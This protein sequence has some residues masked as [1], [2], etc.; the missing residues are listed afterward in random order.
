LDPLGLFTRDFYEVRI[1]LGWK[2]VEQR[3][4]AA[5]GPP[6][7]SSPVAIPQQAQGVPPASR[8]GAFP[9]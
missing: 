3:E 5:A 9:R 4:P 2:K 6:P 1:P 8:Q 7:A